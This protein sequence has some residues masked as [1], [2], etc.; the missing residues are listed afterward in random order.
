MAHNTGGQVPERVVGCRLPGGLAGVW[1]SVWNISINNGLAGKRI[2]TVVSAILRVCTRGVCVVNTGA[3]PRRREQH[4]Y[5]VH[6]TSP[7]VDT[8][9]SCDLG[10]DLSI[11]DATAQ[12]RGIRATRCRIRRVVQ[13]VPEQTTI[14]RNICR[15]AADC[16]IVLRCDILN[17]MTRKPTTHQYCRCRVVRANDGWSAGLERRRNT[18]NCVDSDGWVHHCAPRM[19]Q[20]CGCGW[21]WA[22]EA[23]S[24]A[25]CCPL[26]CGMDVH[27]VAIW[28]DVGQLRHSPRQ[29]GRMQRNILQRHRRGSRRCSRKHVAVRK[30]NYRWPVGC[31]LRPSSGIKARDTDGRHEDLCQFLHWVLPWLSSSMK[32]SLKLSNTLQVLC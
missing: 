29:F 8:H 10:L 21:G 32:C 18:K 30:L 27:D 26:G 7:A 23:G 15:S 3:F 12:R 22:R 19:I 11:R 17:A 28:T 24:V 13:V 16:L 6:A 20:K 31:R 9:D 5:L 25:C 4:E 14:V 1:I 2:S